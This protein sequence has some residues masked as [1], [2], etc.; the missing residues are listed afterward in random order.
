MRIYGISSVHPHACGENLIARRRT[1]R[2]STGSPPRLWGKLRRLVYP[3]VR[4]ATGSPPRL[5]GK[6]RLRPGRSQLR[7]TQHQVMRRFTPTPVGKTDPGRGAPGSDP[8][9]SPP[10]LWGKRTGSIARFSWL[11]SPPRLWGKLPGQC[12]QGTAVGR[13]TPTPVG[14]T[15]KVASAGIKT[16]VHPHACGENSRGSTVLAIANGSP[17]RLWGKPPLA[18]GTLPGWRFTPTPVGKTKF[19]ELT[20]F[21]ECRFTPTPVGK[22][23]CK[24]DL[25]GTLERFTPTPVG[26]TWSGVA[27][28]QYRTVHPHACGENDIS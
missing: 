18:T 8:A 1:A 5:W 15:S 11:G 24:H 13:F 17:P 16:A 27:P 26:K 7:E 12:S 23:F 9:G 10:R 3:S 20:L 21:G 4:S 2:G 22:T 6:P 28:E 25:S 19:S 14:K